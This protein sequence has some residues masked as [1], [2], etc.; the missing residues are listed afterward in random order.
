MFVKFASFF[1]H[2][3]RMLMRDSLYPARYKF[4]QRYDPLLK[5]RSI[6]SSFKHDFFIIIIRKRIRIYAKY[7]RRVYDNKNEIPIFKSYLPQNDRDIIRM[8]IDCEFITLSK[9]VFYL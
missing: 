9:R 1:L 8:L 6:E 7:N 4:W 2:M 3:Q 5:F